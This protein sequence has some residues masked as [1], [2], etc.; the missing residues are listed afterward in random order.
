[1]A[2][3]TPAIWSWNLTGRGKGVKVCRCPS[4][5]LRVRGIDPRDGYENTDPPISLA[6]KAI[7]SPGSP[8]VWPLTYCS[9]SPYFQVAHILELASTP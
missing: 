6:F 8:Y 7:A 9:L 2:V 1:M 4:L 5:W 3:F